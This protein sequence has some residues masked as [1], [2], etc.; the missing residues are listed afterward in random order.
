MWGTGGRGVSLREASGQS[1]GTA[2]IKAGTEAAVL[3]HAELQVGSVDEA[4]PVTRG[5]IVK[6]SHGVA[7]G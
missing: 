5:L 7:G 3:R 6:R 1:A 4:C 2:A